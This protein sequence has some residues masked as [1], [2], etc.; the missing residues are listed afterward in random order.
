MASSRSSSGKNPGSKSLV[1]SE[2]TDAMFVRLEASSV[3]FGKKSSPD[4]QSRGLIV[5]WSGMDELYSAFKAK[6]QNEA[7]RF[8]NL[9]WFEPSINNIS[10]K[11]T[12]DSESRKW[13]GVHELCWALRLKQT[14]KF[15]YFM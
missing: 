8:T 15:I 10:G 14:E 2:F 7:T 9:F 5:S 1:S 3:M 6:K 11:N 12:S 13:P 4:S